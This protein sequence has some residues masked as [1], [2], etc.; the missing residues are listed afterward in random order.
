[1]QW[2]ILSGIEGNIAAYEAVLKDIRRQGNID[3]LYILGDVIGPRFTSE[4]LIKRIQQQTDLPAQICTG[5]WEEQLFNLY[6][7]GADMNAT[8]LKQRYG[9]AGVERLWNAVS[10]ETA[11]WLRSLNFGF[12]EFDCLLIHGSTVG[13]DD[14]LTPETE[15][16]TL[17]DRILRSEAN[18]LFCG[19][20][21]L[22]FQYQVM[23]GDLSSTVQTLDA[24]PPLAV[25][26][27]LTPRQVIGVGNVGRQSGHASY[28]LY[29]PYNNKVDFRTV[30]Y[31][32][33]AQGFAKRH[34]S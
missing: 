16:I 29:N 19:R 22:T 28:T 12:F 33:T 8:Q 27:S 3:E 1:M 30:T 5:W 24:A 23:A 7:W 21:G 2:A 26:H 14:E 4:Q 18:S 20:S 25:E 17:L 9:V 34:S 31:R 13:C 15:P 11:Q 10:R 6:G 32:P